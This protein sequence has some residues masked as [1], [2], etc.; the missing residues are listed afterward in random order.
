MKSRWQRGPVD[1]QHAPV[2]MRFID[3]FMTALGSLVFVALLLVFLLPKTTQQKVSQE[4]LNKKIEELTKENE[5]LRRRQRQQPQTSPSTGGGQTEDANIVR[6]WFGVTLVTSGCKDKGPEFYVRWEGRLINSLTSEPRPDAVPFDAANP[7]QKDIVNGH[8]Y[9]D[10]GAG[11]DPSH[12]ESAQSE[13]DFAGLDA[14]SRSGLRSKLFHG[15]NRSP[16]SYSVYVG[17]SDPLAQADI[18]CTISPIYLAHRGLIQGEKITL[19]ERQPF[20]WLRRFKINTDGTTTMGTPPRAD[21]QFKRDLAEFSRKQSETLCQ[22]KTICGTI[23]AHQAL[24]LPSPPAADGRAPLTADQERVLKPKH[25]FTECEKCPQMVMMPLGS[26]TMGSPVTEAERRENEGLQAAVTFSRRFAVGRFAVTYE[27]WDACV[28]DRGCGNYSPSDRGGGRGNRPVINVS[29]NDAK[30]YVAWLAKKTG[31]PYRLLSEAER[32]YVSRA[33]AASSF[34]WGD[35]ISLDQANYNGR[36]YAGGRTGESRRRT[37]PVDSFAPNAWGLYNVHGNVAEWTEDCDVP[38]KQLVAQA[39]G[40][41]HVSTECAMRVVRGG[42]FVTD[43][44]YL[45]AASRDSAIPGARLEY[46][47]FRVARSFLGGQSGEIAWLIGPGTPIVV[48]GVIRGYSNFALSPLQSPPA[49]GPLPRGLVLKARDIATLWNE[50]TNGAIRE[51]KPY[52]CFELVESTPASQTFVRVKPTSC[53][54]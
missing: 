44:A 31:R 19:T 54:F 43:P 49:G 3:M 38:K 42:S 10:I 50:Q 11:T 51:I 32:E 34:W 53:T 27:E 23:D 46:I 16:G 40:S 45:R 22:K 6:R 28:A 41:P 14:F 21:D 48:S 36:A 26:F 5:E 47:G 8:S 20:A 9:T 2:E 24:L 17:L 15:I 52:E 1:E 35:T 12:L 29:W 7:A 39:D 25:D 30:A 18:E 13:A 4:E 37:L 33:G